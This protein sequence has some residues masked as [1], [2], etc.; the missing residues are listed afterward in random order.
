MEKFKNTL[1]KSEEEFEKFI[2]QLTVKLNNEK[3][4]DL[5]W[6]ERF[7][8]YGAKN[9]DETIEKLMD[10]YYSESYR[11]REYRLG[12]QPREELMWLLFDYAQKYCKICED[13][14]FY[15]N[16]TSGAF[17]VGSYVIQIMNGQGSI[18]R[19]DRIDSVVK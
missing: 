14:R 15:N 16:F 7:K 3:E 10:K 6:V 2:N 17:Y 4:F 18:I 13:E 8:K 5:R 11:N 12:Y 1:F 9:I 19:I